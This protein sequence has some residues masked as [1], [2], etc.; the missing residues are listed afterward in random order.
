MSTA[1]SLQNLAA[2]PNALSNSTH[3]GLLLQRKCACGSPTSSLTGECAECKSRKRV[4][5]KLAIGAS[6]D[7][8]EQEADRVADQV[9]AAPAHPAVGSAP[10]RIQRYTG[11]AT[12]RTNT[13][14]ATVD[15][16]LATPGRPLDA[17]L[18]QDMEQRFGHDFSR[19]RVHS[20]GA[21][22]Q[23]ARE[24]NAHAYTV[25]SHIVFG[26]GEYSPHAGGGR[27]L[28]AHELAHVVQS[29]GTS[30]TLATRG[31]DGGPRDPLEREADQAAEDVIAG[32][33]PQ[34]HGR[35]AGGRLHR[36][37]IVDEP[38]GGCGTCLSATL[39]GSLVHDLV[40]AAFPITHQNEARFTIPASGGDAVLDLLHITLSPGNPPSTIEVGEIKPNNVEGIKD[41]AKDLIFYMGA[42][43]SRF[44][45][46]WWEVVPMLLPPPLIAMPFRDGVSPVCPTQQVTVVNSGGLY[47]YSCAPPRSLIPSTCCLPLPVA[48]PETKDVKDKEKDKEPVK[49]PVGTPVPIPAFAR[50]LAGLLAALAAGALLVAKFGGKRVMVPLMAMAAIVLLANGAEASVGLEGDDALEALFKLSDSKGKPIPDDIKDALRKDPEMRKLLTDAAKSGKY[51]EAQ[52][53]AGEA[54]TRAILANRDAFTQEELEILLKATE[55]NKSSLPQGE[56]TVEELKKQIEARKKVKGS[57][58]TTDT[59][60]PGEG[61]TEG[62]GGKTA[63]KARPTGTDGGPSVPLP[64][65]TSPPERLVA[66]LAQAGGGGPKFSVKLKDR[67]LA[68]ARAVVP[69][70]TDSEVT[71]LLE[72][73][74]SAQGKTDDEIVASVERGIGEVRKQ[75]TVSEGQPGDAST[76]ADATKGQPPAPNTGPKIEVDKPDPNKK[77]T[78]GEQEIIAEYDKVIDKLEWVKVDHSFLVMKN[79]PYEIGKT[80]SMTLFGRNSGGTLY[81]GSV[82]V[83][84]VSKGSDTWKVTIAGGS[85]LY[86]KGAIYGTVRAETDN[87]VPSDIAKGGGTKK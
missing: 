49:P 73:V 52:R 56:V 4:Q 45:S 86:T 28:L 31:V 38:A 21:A 19:V 70:L 76:D 25:G 24:V 27:E 1:A 75:K 16:V 32:R 57:A 42:L 35:A 12:E 2:K 65:T 63:D 5:T 9:L 17:A 22:E 23:S 80:Y 15:Q 47:L 51:T 41:G 20:D 74:A 87:V 44:P 54:V 7:P 64:P 68:A 11:Q 55:G 40:Q 84:I 48:E 53:Q 33:P 58:A 61:G 3:A 71:K 59:G 13:A 37:V 46:P 85:T 36:Q 60:K 79:P 10:P 6:N 81:I 78:K 43:R 14:P 26:A 69:P 34:I 39:V 77:V 30:G 67:L 72:R 62:G 8:L 50:D 18:R 29:S 83:M 82:N 66:G